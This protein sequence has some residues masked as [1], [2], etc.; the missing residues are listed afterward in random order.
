[1]MPLK[2]QK[3]LTILAPWKFVLMNS[4]FL[5][6][7]SC[8]KRL[9]VIYI[10]LL[11]YATKTTNPVFRMQSIIRPNESSR[12]KQLE[13]TKSDRNVSS[14]QILIIFTT[15]PKSFSCKFLLRRLDHI[16]LYIT[17]IC[18]LY[19]SLFSSLFIHIWKN[20]FCYRVDVLNVWKDGFKTRGE[21]R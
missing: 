16:K 5:N 11:I 10:S 18:M 17:C 2:R 19:I 8:S 9:Y 13:H 20:L 14:G 3:R 1:M 4:A 12:A 21:E 7:A 6:D 15:M